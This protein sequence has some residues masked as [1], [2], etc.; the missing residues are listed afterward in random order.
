MFEIQ[1][2]NFKPNVYR[3]HFDTPDHKKNSK[4]RFLFY[5]LYSLFLYVPKYVCN[6]GSTHLYYTC[7]C[8]SKRGSTT[9]TQRIQTNSELMFWHPEWLHRHGKPSPVTG[10]RGPGNVDGEVTEW[11]MESSKRR[12]S[13]GV[14]PMKYILSPNKTECQD[15]RFLGLSSIVVLTNKDSRDSLLDKVWTEDRKPS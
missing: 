10:N 13:C 14:W 2:R 7:V 5:L 6:K 15:L 4:D 9:V 3:L 1:S 12:Q 8:R 11:T